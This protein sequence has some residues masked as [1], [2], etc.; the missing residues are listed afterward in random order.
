MVD[1][2]RIDI[3]NELL[4]KSHKDLDVMRDKGEVEL[5]V[6]IRLI[7]LQDVETLIPLNGDMV[8]DSLEKKLARSLDENQDL[9]SK[10]DTSRS[11]ANSLEQKIASLQAR[12]QSYEEEKL[13]VFQDELPRKKIHLSDD[14]E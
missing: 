7:L 9:K 10:L 1:V 14:I 13:R 8:V 6:A 3:E 11:Y 5:P 12:I 2:G 4:A